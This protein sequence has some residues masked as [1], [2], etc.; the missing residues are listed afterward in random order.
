MIYSLGVDEF[1]ARTILFPQMQNALPRSAAPAFLASRSI[2][3]G[4]SAPTSGH[5]PRFQWDSNFLPLFP[6][7][8]RR[9]PPPPYERHLNCARPAFLVRYFYLGHLPSPLSR[10]HFLLRERGTLPE[11][12]QVLLPRP[13]VGF[14]G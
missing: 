13:W 5:Y 10:P 8:P 14:P 2:L 12:R 7:P 6:L 9:R 4:L 1:Q 3:T 11:Y